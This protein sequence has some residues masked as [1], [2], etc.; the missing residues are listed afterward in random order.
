MLITQYLMKA[1]GDG[2]IE[3]SP[4]F[5]GTMDW[6]FAVICAG[7]RV[8]KEEIAGM[9]MTHVRMMLPPAFDLKKYETLHDFMFNE[10]VMFTYP[11][12]PG[13]QKEEEA[14]L[15]CECIAEVVKDETKQWLQSEG[16]LKGA[17]PGALGS[18]CTLVAT[19]MLTTLFHLPIR[20]GVFENQMAKRCVTAELE[21]VFR[22][23]YGHDKA[24]KR[25][26]KSTMRGK[27]LEDT[28][29]I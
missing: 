10:S 20:D 28:L 29:G 12:P 4:V 14:R 26:P 24:I 11:A 3:Q 21:S 13:V 15:I 22:G 23:F 1:H 5:H 27:W 17:E 25:F 19:G 2:D 9:K 16:A 6:L 18:F 8:E 7:Q